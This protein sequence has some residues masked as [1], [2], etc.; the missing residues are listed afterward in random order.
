MTEFVLDLGEDPVARAR[1]RGLDLFTQQH[2]TALFYTE[3]SELDGLTFCD[4]APETLDELIADCA[5][6]QA[7]NSQ[8]LYAAALADSNCDDERAGRDFWYTRTG[9]G[10]G[11]DDGDWPAPYA[12]FLTEASRNHGWPE[13][14]VGDDRRIYLVSNKG[15]AAA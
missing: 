9:C 5:A 7:Q 13:V 4:L 2:I 14:Y 10:C 15:Q 3:Q 8:S 12:K 11:F 6:F 1:F